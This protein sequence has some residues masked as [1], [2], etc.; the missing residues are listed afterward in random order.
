ME[1]RVIRKHN[2]QIL[3]EELNYLESQGKIDSNKKYEIL[4]MYQVSKSFSFIRVILIISALLIGVGI[5]IF[6]AGN[7]KEMSHLSKFLYIAI[8]VLGCNLV[9]YKINKTSPKTGISLIYLGCLIYGAGIVLIEQMFNYITIFSD[10]CFIWSLGI[11]PIGLYFKDNIIKIFSQI[12]LIF[13]LAN[14]NQSILKLLLISLIILGI[15]LLIVKVKNNNPIIKTLNIIIP[16]IVIITFSNL[17]LINIIYIALLFFILGI[18]STFVENLKKYKE[19]QLVGTLLYGISGIYITLGESWQGIFNSNTSNIISI[20]FSVGFF[21]FLIILLKQERISS[22]IFICALVLRY[23]AD[24]SYNF[25]PKSMF[26]II[27]GLI[28]GGFGYWFE[29]N[30]KKGGKAVE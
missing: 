11:I 17:L 20:T 12:L 24:Y 29:K 4:D 2:Y 5:L 21:I 18:I 14:Y 9:G 28:L 3:N 22:I 25:M 6:V 26:F 23:Y 19:L 8:A 1:K 13:Y 16:L 15:I 30:R 27:G 10:T 7:W